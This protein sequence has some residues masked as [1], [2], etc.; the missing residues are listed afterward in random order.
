MFVEKVLNENRNLVATT[1]NLHQQGFI[2]PDS[3]VIDV[4]Q[5][6]SNAKMILDEA[7]KH[8]M[9]LYFMLKQ[10]GRNPYL[11][12]ALVNMGYQGAVVV[13][14]KEAQVMMKHQIP[15]GNVGHLVQVPQAQLKSII[16]YGCEVMTV[17][18]IEKIRSIEQACAQL[19]KQQAILLR[20]VGEDDLIYPG[21]TAGFK[22]NELNELIAEVKTM[23]YVSIAGVTSFPCF[24]YDEAVKE[25]RPTN[26]LKTVKAASELLR[27]HGIEVKQ[28]NTPST[29]CVSTIH[30]MALHGGTHGEP[31]HGLTGTTPAHAFTHLEEVPCILYLSE[32]SHNYENQAFCF[33]GGYYRRSHMENALVASS[34]DS[35]KKTKVFEPTMDNIDYHFTLKEN[36]A[37]GE[38]VIMAFRFQIFV[39]R[40]NVVLI[41]GITTGKPKIVGVYDSLGGLK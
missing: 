41:E 5:F 34:M 3:Y 32:V 6:L 13:D 30:Q 2:E 7:N 18:S 19:H 24:L 12:Q 10:V 33:G 9:I 36:F 25:T 35:L 29:T 40:S 17:Y 11:A 20:V 15:L 26:N 23:K 14:F 1:I 38:S 16:D 4:D 21:Q 27:K 39:T 8:Q 31:G 28:I 22:L 37:I